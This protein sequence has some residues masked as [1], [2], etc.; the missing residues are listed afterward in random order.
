MP[1][2]RY[3]LPIA[4][5]SAAVLAFELGLMQVFSITQWYHFAYMAISVAMLG[6]G[7]AGTFLA[8]FEKK[9]LGRF[10]RAFPLLL[11]ACGVAMAGACILAQH[12]AVRFDTYLL[13]NDYRQAGRLLATY[14]IFFVPFFLAALAIGLAFVRFSGQ[15]GQLYF[16]DLLGTALGGLLGVGLLWLFPPG[17]LPGLVALLPVLGGLISIPRPRDRLW[18]V[19]TPLAIALVAAGIA[20]APR[21]QS[22]QYKSLSKALLLPEAAVEAERCSPYGLLQVVSAPA[23]R[24]APGLSLSFQGKVPVRKALFNNGEWAGAVTPMPA[25]D[26]AFILDFTTAALP[27]RLRRPD[28]VLAVEAGTGEP[29]AHALAHRAGA[30]SM[31]ESN[32]AVLSLLKGQLAGETD[33]L[34]FQPSVSVYELEARTFLMADT[35]TYSLILLP[36]VSTFGGGAGLNALQEQYL[37]TQE[38]FREMWGRLQPEGMISLSCWLDYPPRYPLRVLATLVDM[39]AAEGIGEPRR[40]IIAVRS[41]GAITFVAKRSPFSR[42]ETARARAFCEEMLFDPLI[43]DSLQPGERQQYNQLQDTMLFHYADAILSPARDRFYRQYQFSVQPATDERPY[44][45][46]FLRWKS[47]PALAEQWGSRNLPFME[48]GYLVVVLTFFQILLVALALIIL[49]LFRIGFRSGDRG[50]ALSYFGSLGLGFMFVEIILIQQFTLFL[51]KPVFATALAISG[52]LAASGAGS[53]YTSRW[54]Q[55]SGKLWLIPV[56][57]AALLGV[58]AAVLLPA[59]RSA[60][61]LAPGVK[62]FVLLLAVAPLGFL[63]G[64]PFPLGIRRLAGGGRGAVSWAWGVNGYCSVISTALATLIAVEL[65]FSWVM[66]LAGGAYA[67]A[68]VVSRVGVKRRASV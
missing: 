56:L 14:L 26:S 48:L 38:S 6:F 47:L 34:L 50:W 25:P 22:S 65:G 63:M 55:A 64:M 43:L 21:L 66:A 51:G 24:H 60:V 68:G 41:W 44:F 42:R 18:W 40:H 49:P 37:M 11:L 36:T 32:P 54:K 9:L 45:S 10:E 30:I 29:V 5:A 57:I 58:Y 20:G 33:S 39:L 46:Q 1:L 15:I 2:P 27:F 3:A 23:L 8:L 19:A 67:L 59:L 4:L 61:G 13:F 17:R 52:L 28:R 35:Q 12:P 62:P 31:V 16:A 7:A 53:W